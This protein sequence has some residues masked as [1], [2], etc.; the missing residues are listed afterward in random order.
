M[1]TMALALDLDGNLSL[2]GA[3]D[4]VHI[5]LL[6]DADRRAPIRLECIDLK[7]EPLEQLH[8]SVCDDLCREIQ[9]GRLDLSKLNDALGMEP[10]NNAK[11]W[12]KD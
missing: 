10:H 11:L 12:Q 5:V 6:K 3:T 8:A 9:T 1:T 4:D 7:S 2:L